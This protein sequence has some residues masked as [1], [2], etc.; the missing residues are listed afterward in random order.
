MSLGAAQALG[1]A[2]AA[3][4][5]AVLVAGAALAVLVLVLAGRAGAGRCFDRW[6]KQR[7][8]F[9]LTVCMSEVKVVRKSKKALFFIH[10]EED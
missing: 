7:T 10:T 5:Q 9:A 1:P 2:G 3:A 4:R 6:S 8:H